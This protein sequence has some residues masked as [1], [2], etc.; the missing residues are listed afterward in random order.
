MLHQAIKCLAALAGAAIF[1]Q[2]PA[3][4]SDYVQR[5][6]GRLDQARTQVER[7]E[8][9]AQ[10]ENLDLQAFVTV[11]LQNDKSPVRRLGRV[12][13]DQINELE[14]LEA[15][16][17]ALRQAPVPVRPWRFARHAERELARA[18]LEDFTPA[19]PLGLE[20]LAYAA[21]GL[22]MGL[23]LAEGGRRGARA[24]VPKRST[25]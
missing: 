14:R 6:G 2:F 21:A 22:L 15:A 9:A 25:A 18:T 10:A 23:G 4:Y 8:T 11:F 19:L 20:G 7:L 24:L 12:M 1:A 13:N 16:A 5:L 3:F 17:A